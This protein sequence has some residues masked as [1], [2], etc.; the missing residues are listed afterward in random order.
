MA[1][2]FN[3]IKYFWVIIG[4]KPKNILTINKG[5]NKIFNPSIK[6]TFI[7]PSKHNLLLKV[8]SSICFLDHIS[9]CLYK[10][11]LIDPWLP[12]LPLRPQQHGES[13][14][15]HLLSQCSWC[16]TKGSSK[17]ESHP[18]SPTNVNNP[19]YQVRISKSYVG[20]WQSSSSVVT[21]C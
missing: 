6:M 14:H 9:Q 18:W 19:W 5:K 7:F 3:I 17:D 15:W 11:Y 16:P 10:S 2:L 13:W 20:M 1:N 4:N 21:I 12:F 8:K